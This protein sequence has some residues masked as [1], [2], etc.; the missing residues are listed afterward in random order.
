MSPESAKAVGEA[1]CALWEGEFPA[2][3]NVLRAVR[4]EGRDYRPDRKS[5][6]SWELVVHL[7]TADLWFIDCIARGAFHFDRE[8]AKRRQDL[9]PLRR[10]PALAVE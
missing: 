4:D 9:P 10:A 6:S 5:R 3:V 8:A 7:A 1:M 2:T